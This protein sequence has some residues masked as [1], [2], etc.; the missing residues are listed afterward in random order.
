MFKKL[1]IQYKIIKKFI[2][3]IRTKDFTLYKIQ[4]FIISKYQKTPKKKGKEK[5][6]DCGTLQTMYH[7]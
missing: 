7:P 3:R 5:H 4:Y 1:I 2:R 6:G